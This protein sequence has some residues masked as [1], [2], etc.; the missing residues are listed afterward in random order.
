MRKSISFFV[1][2]Q[3]PTSLTAKP[4]RKNILNSFDYTGNMVGIERLQEEGNVD[5]KKRIWDASVNPSGTVYQSLMNGLTRSFGFLKKEI[6]EITLKNNSSGDQ[7]A[8]SPRID[9]LANKIILYKT[10]HPNGNNIIDKEIR[11][12]KSEDS[13]Y[14]LIDLVS[15][16][17]SSECFS[18]SII[19]NIR[20]NTH[21][22]SLIRKS[23]HI[24]VSEELIKQ[25]KQNIM[26]NK[27]IVRGTVVF[28]DKE[29][30]ID[31]VESSPTSN[32]EYHID[33]ENAVIESYNIPNIR[34]YCSYHANNFPLK[35]EY[36]PIQ[37]FSINDDNYMDELF[38]KDIL[39]SN[40]EINSLPNE[41]GTIIF[42][43]IFNNVKTF[44]GE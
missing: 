33:Y 8:F 11:T 41:E 37:V 26:N 14:W 40:E 18:C 30:F 34:T 31:E 39:D 32:G 25:S 21:S 19:D 6:L 24:Y 15:E 16:I 28:E 2:I 36:S 7:I 5:L 17:N 20:G 4:E 29:N 38:N 3:N 42:N 12:Y 35:I 9:I 13:G 10:W 44:W 23:S 1:N 27:N 22:S 43:K